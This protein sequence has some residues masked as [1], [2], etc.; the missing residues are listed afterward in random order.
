M[1][2]NRAIRR[3]H[4]ARTPRRLSTRASTPTLSDITTASISTTTSIRNTFLQ[5][6]RRRTSWNQQHT[7]VRDNAAGE[8]LRSPRAADVPPARRVLAR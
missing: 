1:T 4:F 3:H 8:W 2:I 7:N 5:S 6:C